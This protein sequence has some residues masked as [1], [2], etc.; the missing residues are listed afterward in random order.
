MGAILDA[1]TARAQAFPEITGKVL[2]G[3]QGWHACPGDQK[4]TG[5]THWTRGGAP[6]PD[7]L[8]VDMYPDLSEFGA[9]ELCP[10]TGF[11][12][13]GR[14]A[15]FFSSRHPKSV[16]RH[17]RWMKEYGLDGVLV[18]RFLTEAPGKRS[19]GD[20]VLRNVM[21]GALAH[22]R[23]FAVEYD[24]S[25]AGE[26][27]LLERLK[28]DWT[29]LVDEVKV[30]A[31]PGYL[32]HQ[33]RPVLAVWGMGLNDGN[34]P[35][36]AP[37]AAA[38]PGEMV[39]AGR[40]EN[41]R[42]AFLGGVPSGWRTLDGDAYPDAAWAAVYDSMDIVQP[43]TV[44]RYADSAGVDRWRTQRLEGDAARTRQQ[45]RAYQ[46]VIWPGFSWKNLNAGAANQVPRKGG[47]FLW[48]QA[49][50]AKRAGAPMLKIAM[51]DE[52]DESTAMY[53][54]AARRAD[55]PGPGLLAH[56][57]RGRPGPAFR[58]VPPGRE[59]GNT[60]VSVTR[61]RCRKPCPSSPGIP[62]RES[63]R[64]RLR[65]PRR[66]RVRGAG[67]RVLRVAGGF[68]FERGIA[69]A[70]EVLAGMTGIRILDLEGRLLRSLPAASGAA[71]WDGL[72]ARGAPPRNRDISGVGRGRNGG[73]LL[74]R[75]V[76]TLTRD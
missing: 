37:A 14:T 50:N 44:G 65:V 8:V 72:D 68:R 67:L 20:V 66:L 63:A 62:R 71:G 76:F 1:G 57:G 58:L 13:G 2:F 26:A 47:S 38:A 41:H 3:Y 46:P 27:D 36:A 25:G 54:L 4:G 23:A 59:C 39:P 53:K 16:D 49:V 9:D 21:A 73:S 19:G 17:F 42:A 75:A 64:R 22:G 51:F 61:F 35:P 30:T 45:G 29:Y 60:H 69:E 10:V 48:R 18:Q 5:W 28:T 40:G 7:N 12:V 32:R 15:A 34:H 56:P 6:T 70:A 74:A 31:H 24:L 55:A 33:G 52:V 11:T 43:W